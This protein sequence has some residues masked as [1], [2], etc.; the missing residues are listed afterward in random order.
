MLTRLHTHVVI[1]AVSA[2]A[3]SVV[4]ATSSVV[5]TTCVVL[6]I[7]YNRAAGTVEGIICSIQAGRLAVDLAVELHTRGA[8]SGDV[9]DTIKLQFH[10]VHQRFQ[11]RTGEETHAQLDELV[12]ISLPRIR[13]GNALAGQGE[14]S[15]N[16][17]LFIQHGRAVLVDNGDAVQVEIITET[18]VTSTLFDEGK[19]PANILHFYRHTHTL[20]IIDMVTCNLYGYFLWV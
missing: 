20:S 10:L 5:A 19:Y 9:I 12:D 7:A 13:F 11:L 2:T 16:S 6:T 14:D 18:L 8:L 1:T 4:I 15:K 17:L 3:T